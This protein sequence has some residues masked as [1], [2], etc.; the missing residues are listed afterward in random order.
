MHITH[1]EQ[2]DYVLKVDQLDEELLAEALQSIKAI[3]VG[4][5]EYVDRLLGT[6]QIAQLIRIDELE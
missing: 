6:I 3:L 1:I 5:D 2:F 4:S